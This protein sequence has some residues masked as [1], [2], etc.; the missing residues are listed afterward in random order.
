MAHRYPVGL[1]HGINVLAPS[2][3]GDVFEVVAL[4]RMLNQPAGAVLTR[5]LFRF[6]HLAALGVLAAIAVGS[7]DLGAG[8]ARV[9][10]LR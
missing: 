7:V 3:L 1:S 4:G 6:Y 9:Q 8:F 2:L 10:S 5:L